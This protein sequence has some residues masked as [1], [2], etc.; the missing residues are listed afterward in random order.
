MSTASVIWVSKAYNWSTIQEM[1]IRTKMPGNMRYTKTGALSG[2]C[3]QGAGNMSYLPCVILGLN[4]AVLITLLLVLHKQRRSYQY[5]Q[6]FIEQYLNAERV[7]HAHIREHVIREKDLSWAVGLPPIVTFGIKE[8][9]TFMSE[10]EQLEA[11]RI[12][13]L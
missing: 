5:Y 7:I 3:Y 10:E 4:I 1:F 11:R 6:E 12:A 9:G 13:G 8:D 2:L